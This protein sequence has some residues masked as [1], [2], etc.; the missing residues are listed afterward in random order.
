MPGE[1]AWPL[2]KL[3]IIPEWM[4]DANGDGLV[5]SPNDE[6]M[7]GCIRLDFHPGNMPVS[8]TVMDV[9]PYNRRFDF[10][11]G[12][13]RVTFPES[14]TLGDNSVVRVQL[15]TYGYQRIEVCFDGSGAIAEVEYHMATAVE[16]HT[17]GRVKGMY[18]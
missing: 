5:D 8:L 10:P 14:A 18:R 16:E 17:W 12:A 13:L 3:L 2:G 4:T 6:A 15:P 1:N 7:G 9:D 11:P